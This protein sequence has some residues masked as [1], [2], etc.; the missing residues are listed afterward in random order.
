MIEAEI[1]QVIARLRQKTASFGRDYTEDGPLRTEGEEQFKVQPDA[2]AA[3]FEDWVMPLTKEVEVM[4]L[5]R[6]LEWE[7]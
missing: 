4:Y 5:L 2:V 1:L 3:L 7:K 6:R